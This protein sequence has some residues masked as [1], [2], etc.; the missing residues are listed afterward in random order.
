MD[1]YFIRNIFLILGCIFIF[2][3]AGLAG[4]LGWLFKGFK[5]NDEEPGTEDEVS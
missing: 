5:E 1:F 4:Y 2:I 3:M